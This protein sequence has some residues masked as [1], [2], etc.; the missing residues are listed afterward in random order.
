MT[1]IKKVKISI[2]LVAACV[3]ISIAVSSCGVSNL[4]PQEGYDLGYGLGKA[5][6]TSL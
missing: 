6:G 1:I 3:A 2:L 4:T 5:I